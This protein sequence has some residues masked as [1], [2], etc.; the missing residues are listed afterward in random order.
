MKKRGWRRPLANDRPDWRDPDMPVL[1]CHKT[2]GL[3][4][5]DPEYARGM[6]QYKLRTN[7]V[8]DWRRDPTY[9]LKRTGRKRN[10]AAA[11]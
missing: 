3:V 2:K 7:P 10:G 8:P 11:R 1:C 6:A 9:D 4:A 5:V